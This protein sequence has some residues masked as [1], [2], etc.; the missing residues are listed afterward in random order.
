M[1]MKRCFVRMLVLV[2]LLVTL[3]LGE[4][5]CYGYGSMNKENNESDDDGSITNC[6]HYI[7]GMV[8]DADGEALGGVKV[9]LKGKKGYSESCKS[10]ED[11]Y[12]G[13]FD[14][15]EDWE[16]MAGIYKLSF[17]K[18][19]YKSYKTK[20]SFDGKSFLEFFP[21]LEEK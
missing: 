21:E 13:F 15:C 6:G 19:G 8:Y 1:K 11:G 4:V 3:S 12:F 7:E 17:K 18:A 9:T 16:D 5:L 10:E 20:V 14:G 2:S